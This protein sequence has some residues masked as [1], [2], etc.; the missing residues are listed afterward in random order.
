MVKNDI[1]S[2]YK[3]LVPKA[4]LLD[5]DKR[6]SDWLESGGSLEDNYVKQ[7]ISYLE[8]YIEFNNRQQKA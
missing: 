3:K 7:Q 8:R 1:L 5:A 2:K 4:A 6:I